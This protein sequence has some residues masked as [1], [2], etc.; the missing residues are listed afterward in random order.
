MVLIFKQKFEWEEKTLENVESKSKSNQTG[1]GG[2]CQ[3]KLSRN[4]VLERRVNVPEIVVDR[5][6]VQRR[7]EIKHP[8]FFDA[9]PRSSKIDFLAFVLFVFLYVI[10]NAIYL[11]CF[12]LNYV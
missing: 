3:E 7:S 1:K 10:F 11:N 12:V 2:N 4:D 8:G 5:L 9:L 6:M